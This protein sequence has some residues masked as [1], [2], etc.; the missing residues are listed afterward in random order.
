MSKYRE[1]NYSELDCRLEGYLNKYESIINTSKEMEDMIDDIL[2][3]VN[4]CSYPSGKVEQLQSQLQSK[5]AEIERL[6]EKNAILME[7]V[8]FYGEISNYVGSTIKMSNHDDEGDQ[9][10]WY[11][12]KKARE[13]LEKIKEPNG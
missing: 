1:V 10:S 3:L 4:E 5:D 2:K 13:A 12:G 9:F 6:K 7:A 8:E 11:G